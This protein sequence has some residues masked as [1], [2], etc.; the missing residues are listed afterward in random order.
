M[1]GA[2]DHWTNLPV[3]QRRRRIAAAIAIGAGLLAMITILASPH[4]GSGGGAPS[5]D[6]LA[7]RKPAARATHPA[8][9]PHAHPRRQRNVPH[10]VKAPS[11]PAP[12]RPAPAAVP[13]AAP[14]AQPRPSAA[15]HS[16]G[17]LDPRFY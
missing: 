12:P 7:V 16:G 3:E 10:V 2:S 17:S 5:R 15:G 13:A 9:K 1:Q 6:P 11:T 8:A 4:G 14:P